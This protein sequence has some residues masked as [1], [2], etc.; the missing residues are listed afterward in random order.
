MKK[1]FLKTAAALML[2]MMLFCGVF[3]TKVSAASYNDFYIGQTIQV[4]ISAGLRV[5]KAPSTSSAAVG[6]LSQG[7][8]IR[9]MNIVY[10]SADRGWVYA[11]VG[12]VYGYVLAAEGWFKPVAASSTVRVYAYTNMQAK[13]NVASLTVRSK[14]VIASGNVLGYLSRNTVVTAT[15]YTTNGWIRVAYKSGSTTVTGYVYS[16]YVTVSAKSSSSST[17]NSS[18]K[19]TF[20]NVYAYKAKVT[21]SG[22]LY[23]RKSAS[24]TSQV[25]TLLAY[26]ETVPITAY[27]QNW[28]KVTK[29]VN[30]VKQTGYI[31]RK[32]T[33]RIDVL[34]SVRFK[35]SSMTVQWGKAYPLTIV[36]GESL[37]MTKTWTSSN[38]NVVRVSKNGYIVGR[39]KNATATITCKIKA[40]NRTPITISCKVTVK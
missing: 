37:T 40:G 25:I 8:R 36:G 17:T 10:D 3:E 23:M 34:K 12:S 39:K 30:G 22:G 5:R 29:T 35:Y 2:M 24:T 28:Y 11:K 13:V 6:S 21:A 20:Q 33:T 26:G 7:D 38:E 19:E 18:Q 1:N 16:P 31:A 15:G 32:Y 27:S 14:P 4:N 9:I